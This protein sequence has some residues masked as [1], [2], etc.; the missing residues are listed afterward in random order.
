MSVEELRAKLED[1]EYEEKDLT[2]KGIG[3]AAVGMTAGIFGA[4]GGTLAGVGA[5]VI[6]GDIKSYSRAFEETMA[7][8]NEDILNDMSPEGIAA[9]DK[10]ESLWAKWITEPT[11]KHLVEPNIEHGNPLMATIGKVSGEGLPMFL[12][13]EGP[14]AIGATSKGIKTLTNKAFQKIRK[15]EPAAREALV[16]VE[17]GEPVITPDAPLSDRGVSMEVFK[18]FVKITRDPSVSPHEGLGRILKVAFYKPVQVIKDWKSPTLTAMAERIFASTKAD[19]PIKGARRADLID[20][21]SKAW[22]RASTRFDNIVEPIKGRFN[23]VPARAGEAITRGLRTGK[24]PKQYQEITLQVKEFLDQFLHEYIRPVLPEVG[25]VANY[26]PQVW[27]VPHILKYPQR[28]LNKLVS[29]L[30]FDKDVAQNTLRK[31][32]EAEGSPEFYETSGRLLD[33]RDA[34]PWSGRIKQTGGASVKSFERP[35]KIDIPEKVLPV[36]EEFLVN[37]VGDLL[38]TYIRNATKRVEYARLFG[39]KEEVLNAA[40]ARGIEELGIVNNIKAVKELTGDVYGLADALQGK[41]N[42]IQSL[43]LNKWNRRVANYETVLHLGLVSLASFPEMAAPAIQF[44]LVPK[45][46]VKGLGHALI[47]ATAAAERVLRGKRSIPKLRAAKALEEMGAISVTPIQSILAARFTNV[48]SAFTSRFMHFTGLELLTDT[49]KVIAYETINAILKRNAKYLAKGRGDKRARFYK[50]QLK[51]LG[52]EPEQAVQWLDEGMPRRGSLSDI[53]ENTKLRGQRWAVTMPN[54]ATKPLLFSD[55]HFTNLLLFK[56][57]NSVFSN[58]FMKR[59]LSE[60]FS[61]ETLA[62]RQAGIIGGMVAATSIAYYTQF[63]REMVAGYDSKMSQSERLAAAFDRAA[64]TGTF[65]YAFQLVNPYRFGFTDSSAK[66]LFNLLGPA[67]GDTARLV[68][69]L[70]NQDLSKKQKARELARLVPLTNI[71]GGSREATAEAIEEL[72]P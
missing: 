7:P 36:M 72:L 9:M 13:L 39:P 61:K 44:G 1:L 22:G 33:P 19:A 17:T 69:I 64:L 23:T 46:Y 59:A 32:V 20:M 42:P 62:S 56:S 21:T 49:Q 47:E 50:G 10:L 57:F 41:Y 58:L 15:T 67:V 52:I 18:E 30:K 25:E 37:N 4:F 28:F 14:K 26:V 55:P 51:E 54:A 34:G 43:S 68:D 16:D 53:V 3:E 29:E 60:L 66:R 71:V 70:A 63:L 35:R 12:M 40:V 31:I 27:N 24:V 8:I 5:A 38:H 11:E 65:T 2:L 45:A 48:S 6:D